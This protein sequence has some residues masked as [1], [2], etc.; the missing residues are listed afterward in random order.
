MCCSATLA[1]EMSSTSMKAARPTVGAT[2]HGGPIAPA[3]AADAPSH[4]SVTLIAP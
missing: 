3:P 4:G 2:I 1:I